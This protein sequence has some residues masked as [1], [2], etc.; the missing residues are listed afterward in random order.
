M[1]QAKTVKIPQKTSAK[2]KAVTHTVSKYSKG[3]MAPVV[4]SVNPNETLIMDQQTARN[5]TPQAPTI[6]RSLPCEAAHRQKSIDYIRKENM[7][8]AYMFQ[9]T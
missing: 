2:T 5:T 1:T 4:Q 9:M 7:Q 8:T 3:K 6:S